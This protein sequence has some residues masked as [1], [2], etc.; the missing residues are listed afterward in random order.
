MV[1]HGQPPS[2]AMVGT[3]KSL[4]GAPLGPTRR[5]A[6]LTLLLPFAVMFGGIVLSIV[7]ALAISPALGSLASLFVLGGS[8]WYLLIAIQMVAELKSVTRSDE[9]AWWPLFVPIYQ[10]YFMWFVVPQEVAKAKQLLGARKPPQPVVLYIF[11]WH[12]ALASDLN[13]LVR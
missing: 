7:L 1:P 8:V 2:G 3:L 10:L 4:G 5:N 11:L 6:L 13:D 12:F 9:L